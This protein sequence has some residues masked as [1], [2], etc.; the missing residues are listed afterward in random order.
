VPDEDQTISKEFTVV[1]G[2]AMSRKCSGEKSLK[3]KCRGTPIITG[4]AN[5]PSFQVAFDRKDRKT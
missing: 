3:P 4:I 2:A 5:K 1:A